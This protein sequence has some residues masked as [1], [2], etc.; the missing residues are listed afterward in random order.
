MNEKVLGTENISKLFGKYTIPAVIS[1]VISGSQTLIGGMILG[2]HE[3]ANALATVNIVNP[4]V[5]LAMA[6]SFVIAFGALSI[7]GR[8]LGSGDKEI[9]QN[10]FKTALIMIV[11]FASCYGLFGFLN[12][13]MLSKWLGADATLME[14]VVTYLR[15]FSL[16]IM[17]QPLMILTGFA[18]RIVGKPELYLHATLSMLLVNTSLSFLFIK[19]LGLGVQGAALATGLAMMAGFIVT[20]RPMLKKSHTINVFT[21]HFD[22]TTIIPMMYNGSSEGIGSASTALAIYLFNLEFMRRI[23][24]SGVAAFTTIS[25]V[26]TFGTMIIFG[27]ADGLSP[28]VS[29]NFGHQKND[30]VKAVMRLGTIS[31][32][33]VGVL[34]FVSLFLG[35][36]SLAGMFADSEEVTKI[37]ASG[38]VVYAFAFLVNSFNI[39]HSIYFTAIGAAKESAMIALSRGVVWIVIGINTWP[40]FFGITGVWMTIPIAEAMTVLLVVF[41]VKVKPLEK[42]ILVTA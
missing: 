24:P 2:N 8:N 34:L 33:C 38:A 22:K 3:G 17:F 13:R 6:V 9:A 31:G 35:G 19:H 37:A 1:M 10:T 15:T 20:V 18:D 14:G 4:F 30:R 5:Q 29:Y 27:I 21:G 25:F 7:I 40:I 32:F 36:E 42:E 26:V 23:G 11:V 16:F 39:I 28:I 12:P 41:L